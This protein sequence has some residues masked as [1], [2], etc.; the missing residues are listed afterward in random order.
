MTLPLRL[1]GTPGNSQF[2]ERISGYGSVVCNS[3]LRTSRDS[4]T[5]PLI[6]INYFPVQDN[7]TS[8]VYW[9]L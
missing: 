2:D 1:D 6:Y 3:N 5:A 7:R 9:I 8:K 4:S